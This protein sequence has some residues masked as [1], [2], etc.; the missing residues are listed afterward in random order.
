V[1][2]PAQAKSLPARGLRGGGLV[3]VQGAGLPD[4]NQPDPTYRDGGEQEENGREVA[5]PLNRTERQ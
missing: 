2:P 1:E 3:Q 4:A 5:T